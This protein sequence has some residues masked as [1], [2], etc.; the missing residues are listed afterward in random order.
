M[1]RSKFSL[2]HYRMFSSEMGKL[3][4]IQCVPVIPGDSMQGQNSLLIRMSPLNTPV[5]HPV[6]IRVDTWFV[7]YRITDDGW[8]KFITG[9]GGSTPKASVGSGDARLGKFFGINRETGLVNA[10]PYQAYNRIFNERYRD[11]DLVTAIAEDNQDLQNCAWEKDYYTTARPWPAKGG[12]VGIPVNAGDAVTTSTVAVQADGQRRLLDSS[13]AQLTISPAQTGANTGLQVDPNDLRLAAALQRYGEAR[14]R[15]GSRFTEYLRYLGIT[16]SDAR[17]Q[18]PELLGSGR[19]MVNFSEVLQT[20]PNAQNEGV[21]DLFG[22]GIAGVRT[23]KWRRFF[24]EH[25]TVM[26]LLS[27]R[28]KSVYTYT[29]PREYLKEEPEDYFQK[30]LTHIGEQPLW[31]SEVGGG[32]KFDTWGWTPRY[33]EYRSHPSSVSG[34]F[35]SVLNTWHLARSQTGDPVL[36]AAFVTCDPSK[37]IFQA[38][39]NDTVL[40]MCNNHLV[41]RRMLPKSPRPRIM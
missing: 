41:A 38:Q 2:S 26:T 29:T 40:V 3:I 34:E 20:S 35:R 18:D 25:G 33:E 5:M 6:M 23:R 22:H 28:P 1:A 32:G 8:T 31:A 10:H 21:G 17:L 16:P 11:Q 19:G 39:Q 9:Q 7:P 36:N 13:G 30:E 15:Y 37:R 27:L 14:A 12:N 4:P 24:E